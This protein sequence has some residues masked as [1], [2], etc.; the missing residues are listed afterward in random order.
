MEMIVTAVHGHKIELTDLV[1][2]RKG[3]GPGL[4]ITFTNNRG[5]DIRPNDKCTFDLRSEK[6]IWPVKRPRLNLG[7]KNEKRNNNNDKI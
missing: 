1:R 3:R 2:F 7:G 5:L 6:I 4:R